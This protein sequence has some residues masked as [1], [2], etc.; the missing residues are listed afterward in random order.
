VVVVL[1]YLPQRLGH[2]RMVPGVRQA[3][4]E[5]VDCAVLVGPR[6]AVG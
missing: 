6:D 3:V 4:V 5:V 2:Q 1:D